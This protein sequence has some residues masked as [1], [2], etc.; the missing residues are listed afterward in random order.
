M[1]IAPSTRLL[2]LER[3]KLRTLRQRTHNIALR[4]RINALKQQIETAIN[5]Q[6][7]NTWQHTFQGLDTDNIQDTWRI[8]R[9]LTNNTNNISPLKLHD[10][11]AVTNQEKV[12]L[13]ADTLQ[14]IFTAN[15]DTDP[16]FSKVIEKTVKNFLKQTPL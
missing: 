6:L 14:D 16:N 15:P 9:H 1:Q 8:V 5:N 13:F 2:I 3:N 10:R 11:S 12:N 7:S 4:P